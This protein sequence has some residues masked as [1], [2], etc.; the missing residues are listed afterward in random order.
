MECVLAL[1]ADPAEFPISKSEFLERLRISD[2]VSGRECE[3]NFGFADPEWYA[4]VWL[5]RLYWDA[6]PGADSYRIEYTGKLSG[7]QLSLRLDL[8]EVEE[9]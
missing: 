9:P 6:V 2:P 7:E 5:A 4:D 8:K 3:A 1:R